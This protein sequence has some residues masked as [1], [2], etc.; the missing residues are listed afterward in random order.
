MQSF[1]T[2][3]FSLFLICAFK[4]IHKHSFSHIHVLYVIFLLSFNSSYFLTP[5]VIFWGGR[6]LL[7]WGGFFITSS[8]FIVVYFITS[9]YLF[10]TDLY[11]NCKLRN[12]LYITSELW[13]L[14]R[15]AL[16]QYMIGLPRWLSGKESAGQGR[17]PRRCGLDPWVGKIPWKEEMATH[18]S[19]LTGI[20]P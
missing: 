16:W 20:T 5:T 12:I 19:I 3:S 18:S 7:I 14:L 17:S 6:L 11:L 10:V 1:W 2:F 15:F 13:N 8:Y 4:T 9:S